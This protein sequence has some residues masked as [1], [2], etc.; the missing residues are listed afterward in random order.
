MLIVDRSV[1]VV[2]RPARIVY[3]AS[4]LPKLYR[5]LLYGLD[6]LCLSQTNFH[7]LRELGSQPQGGRNIAR[8]K[9]WP[10]S[11]LLGVWVVEV[12]S[13]P[14]HAPSLAECWPL[15]GPFTGFVCRPGQ[16]LAGQPS[17]IHVPASVTPLT[18]LGNPLLPPKN[19]SWITLRA[20]VCFSVLRGPCRH[21]HSLPPSTWSRCLRLSSHPCCESR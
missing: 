17:Q 8:E 15:N 3:H 10:A 9:F 20:A 11:G 16:R 12:P 21:L 14:R 6:C 2:M 4:K 1:S 5:T 18:G 7:L 19:H 13:C